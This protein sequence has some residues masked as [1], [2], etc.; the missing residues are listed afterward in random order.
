LP[1]SLSRPIWLLGATAVFIAS[2]LAS[3]VYA[4]QN[5]AVASS[6][7]PWFSAQPSELEGTWRL[8]SYISNGFLTPVLD[9]TLIIVTFERD[10]TFNGD[11]S[12]NTY[13]GPYEEIQPLLA[14]APFLTSNDTCDRD[15]MEQ[16][17]AYL[18]ALSSTVT[19]TI[20]GTTLTLA[21]AGGLPV[22]I[23]GRSLMSPPVPSSQG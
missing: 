21:G 4:A 15:V 9:N 14:V 22:A 7:A 5:P 16:E 8:D 20:Q 19:F 2:A 13:A 11:A 18:E 10:G 12:C 23:F 6:N 17:E 1:H 3:S